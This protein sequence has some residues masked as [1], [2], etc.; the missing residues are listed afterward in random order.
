MRR[1]RRRRFPRTGAAVLCAAAVAGAGALGGCGQSGP[2]RLPE[3]EK[4]AF[5]AARHPAPAVSVSAA[6]AARAAR[7]AD[8]RRGGPARA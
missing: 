2:L 6:A 4:E 5:S 3:N 8:G 7:A 1:L